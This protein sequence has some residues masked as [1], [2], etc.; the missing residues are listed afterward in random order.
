MDEGDESDM[1]KWAL[2]HLAFWKAE[3]T[4]KPE[5]S[6]GLGVVNG[7]RHY[8]GRDDSLHRARASAVSGELDRLILPEDV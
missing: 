6:H 4:P 3:E 2:A 8:W 5:V 1:T 7:G